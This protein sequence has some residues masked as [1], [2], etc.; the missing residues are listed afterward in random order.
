MNDDYLI[1]EEYQR[2]CEHQWMTIVLCVLCGMEQYTSTSETYY[3]E[4]TIK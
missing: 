2:N 4:V 1:E 3:R